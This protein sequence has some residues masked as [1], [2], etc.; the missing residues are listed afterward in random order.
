MALSIAISN[1][2]GGVGKTVIAV[3]LAEY[4]IEKGGRVLVID[5]DPQG[6]TSRYLIGKRAERGSG[7]SALYADGPPVTPVAVRERL[8]IIPADKDLVEVEA[9]PLAVVEHPRRHLAR[10][11]NDF[12]LIVIDTPPSQGRR[13]I[14]ALAAVDAVVT[15]LG[16]DRASFEGLEDL[17]GDLR[18]V[19]STLNPGL[20][21]LGILVNRFKPS[22]KA[23]R[24]NLQQLRAQL[25][26][27]VL[28]GELEDRS[29]VGTAFDNR[30][31]V[32]KGATGESARVAARQI[33]AA[34][35]TMLQRAHA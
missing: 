3:A 6:N 27:R 11:V 31:P 13:L 33:R 17:L 18:S 8:W 2:K 26:D 35:E 32:W 30:H 15:P 19:R 20:R 9:R 28:P 25:G 21:H 7:S 24:A 16:L 14:G 12:D 22:N 4:S 23:Q 10:L 34:C 29:P 1:Q 5:V